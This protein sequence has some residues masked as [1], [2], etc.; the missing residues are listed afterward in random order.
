MTKRCLPPKG[1]TDLLRRWLEVGLQTS[2]IEVAKQL[3][4]IGVSILSP[5]SSKFEPLV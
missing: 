4:N 5:N 3:T 1:G 2:V